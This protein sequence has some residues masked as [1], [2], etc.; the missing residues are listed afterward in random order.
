MK[1]LVLIPRFPYCLFFLLCFLDCS[2]QNEVKSDAQTLAYE[3]GY[4]IH[5][6]LKFNEVHSDYWG[7]YT[8]DKAGIFVSAAKGLGLNEQE[9]KDYGGNGVK[10]AIN[11][12]QGS[13]TSASLSA[14]IRK[15]EKKCY[16]IMDK[17]GIK[18]DHVE[19]PPS[20][21]A[22][23]KDVH[24]NIDTVEIKNKLTR[25]KY[26]LDYQKTFIS[27]IGLQKI[28]SV[29]FKEIEQ[30]CYENEKFLKKHTLYLN[31]AKQ[32]YENAFN[33]AL[34]DV[35]KLNLPKSNKILLE[36]QDLKTSIGKLELINL[37]YYSIYTENYFQICMDSQAKS[38]KT[39]LY[40]LELSQKLQKNIKK[41]FYTEEK[42]LQL[43]GDV[44][45]E[46]EKDCGNKNGFIKAGNNVLKMQ[47]FYFIYYK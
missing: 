27:Y 6:S 44:I 42:Y 8:E 12:L 2:C 26:C 16:E 5:L 39:N 21:V 4:F 45:N 33:E 40:M 38:N 46:V 47:E 30:V 15:K 35:Q 3:G 29:K 17:Y 23:D 18:I 41:D 25:L 20:S 36:I 31:N 43:K 22:V 28:D 13:W 34:D 7:K 10:E 1:K 11:D 9:I 37:M 14:K 19:S 24:F 32:L